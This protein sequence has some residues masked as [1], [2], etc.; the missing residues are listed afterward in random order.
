M[1][2]GETNLPETI[3]TPESNVVNLLF[4]SLKKIADTQLKDRFLR[5]IKELQI[6]LFHKLCNELQ[7]PRCRRNTLARKGWRPRVLK[8]SRG[9]INLVVLQA[10][11]KYCNR[12]CRPLNDRIGLSFSTRFLNEL[13]EKSIC[14]GLQ[15][16]YARSA[17]IVKN[18]I[19][20][21]ISSEGIR[22]KISEKAAS[23]SFDQPVNHE[24]VMV[25]ST[26]VK[27]GSKRRGNSVYLAI[28]AKRGPEKAGRP[29]IIK[30][31]FHL[32]VG[33][34]APLKEALKTKRVKR[35]VHDGGEDFSHAKIKVQR[36]LFHLIHQ[37]KHYLWQ[38]GVPFEKRAAYQDSLREVLYDKKNGKRRLKRFIT[39]L[40]TEGLTTSAGHLR[41]AK[42]EIFTHVKE[43]DFSFSTTSPLEREMRE[44]NRRAD[45]GARWSDKGVE[46]ILKVLFHYRLNIR[47]LVNPLG[48]QG[49]G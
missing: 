49:S 34:A 28:T 37:L 12:T 8:S 32:H 15:L 14:L 11:C 7:C 38:D 25:D 10:R 9:K 16:S 20:G 30:K 4:D 42:V 35:L 33:N 19:G 23:L 41:G 43:Q 6:D 5:I 17:V 36:C 18:L 31:L 40:E 46:N 2:S 44:L 27:S 47:K 1:L 3:L 26:K 45:N 13:I 48:I 22:R 21:E 39:Q 24:T 29:T